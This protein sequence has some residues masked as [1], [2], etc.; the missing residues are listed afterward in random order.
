MMQVDEMYCEESIRLP[1]TKGGFTNEKKQVMVLTGNTGD[2]PTPSSLCAKAHTSSPNA[3]GSYPNSKTCRGDPYACPTYSNTDAAYTDPC[4]TDGNTNTAYADS[5]PPDSYTDSCATNSNTNTTYA[6]PYP[7]NSYTDSCATNAY[8]CT[9]KYISAHEYTDTDKH[10]AAHK[11]T[12]P[13]D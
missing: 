12:H 9:D 5:Y 2:N 7:S 4:A 1:T 13:T 8:T 3:R 6:D 10:T 11:Y